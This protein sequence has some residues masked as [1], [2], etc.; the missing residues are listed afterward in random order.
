MPPNRKQRRKLGKDV[1]RAMRRNTKLRTAVQAAAQ[2]RP[3]PPGIY[4]P[5]GPKTT[6]ILPPG[7]IIPESARQQIKREQV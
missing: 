6:F 4:V 7:F 2:Q 3:A 1:R 5:T